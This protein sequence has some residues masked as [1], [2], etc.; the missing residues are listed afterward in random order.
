MK[1]MEING[2]LWKLIEALAKEKQGKNLLFVD[3]C[4]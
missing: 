2:N 4:N 1:L 3:Y